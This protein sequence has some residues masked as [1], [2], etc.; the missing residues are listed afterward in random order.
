MQC[1]DTIVDVSQ[2][3]R[4]LALDPNRDSIAGCA[5]RN[6]P[7]DGGGSILRPVLVA[8]ERPLDAVQAQNAR[9]QPVV[10]AVVLAEL[11][12]VEILEAVPFFW[13]RRPGIVFP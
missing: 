13:L 5:E 7:A 12:H 3:Q 2:G 11:L 1:F 9:L 4:A 8:A 10:L 6:L